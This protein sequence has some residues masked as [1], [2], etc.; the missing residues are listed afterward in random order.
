MTIFLLDYLSGKLYTHTYYEKDIKE[1]HP[2]LASLEHVQMSFMTEKEVAL[3]DEIGIDDNTEHL[4][5]R[6]EAL[7]RSNVI[8]QNRT[9]GEYTENRPNSGYIVFNNGSLKVQVEQTQVLSKS[10]RK[11]VNFVLNLKESGQMNYQ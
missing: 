5:L 11:V 4:Q 9:F 8:V 2:M 6:L 1:I 7:H 10:K 3:L